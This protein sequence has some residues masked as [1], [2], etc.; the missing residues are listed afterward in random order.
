MDA[1]T[2]VDSVV[3]L[4]VQMGKRWVDVMAASMGVTSVD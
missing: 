1:S 4:V 2:A 3:G